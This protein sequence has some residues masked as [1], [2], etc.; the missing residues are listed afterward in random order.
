MEG[1]IEWLEAHQ[2]PCYYKK[3][4]GVD[5]LGCGMQSAIIHLLNGNFIESFKAYPALIPVIFLLIFLILHL[6]F[7]FRKG[8]YILKISFIFTVSVMLISYLIKIINH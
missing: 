1:I 2:M 5:C 3:I 6:V 8:A 7:K 4:L